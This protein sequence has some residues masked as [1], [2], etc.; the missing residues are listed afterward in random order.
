MNRKGLAGSLF[1]IVLA[2]IVGVLLSACGPVGTPPDAAVRQEVAQQA[3]DVPE[4]KNFVERQN[5]ANRQE[6]FDNPAQVSWIYCLAQN[7]QIV[8]YGPVQGKVTSSGKRLEPKSLSGPSGDYYTRGTLEFDGKWTT[9]RIQADGTFG[10]SDQYVY[11][12][13]P[14]GNYFQWSG[15]YFLTSVPI[16]IDNAVLNV[17][18]V[19]EGGE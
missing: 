8:F 18:D 4:V 7:G 17:R 5:I 13:D 12:F 9:E 14:A 11:W 1:V 16:K 2:G 6:L 15:P 10:D 3:V 19:T